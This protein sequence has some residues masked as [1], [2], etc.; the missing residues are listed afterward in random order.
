MRRIEPFRPDRPPK[1]MFSRVLSGDARG[2]AAWGAG[3]R[4][5]VLFFAAGAILTFVFG[6]GE[7]PPDLRR[8]AFERIAQRVNEPLRALQ[9]F[10][11]RIAAPGKG[12]VVYIDA[13]SAAC[14]EAAPH[15]EQLQ[16]LDLPTDDAGQPAAAAEAVRRAAGHFLEGVAPCRGPGPAGP[17]AVRGCVFQ[18]IR[19]WS[20]LAASVERL[21]KDAAWFGVEVEPL[22]PQP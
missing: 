15:V 22:A 9:P 10:R 20:S 4:L 11:A 14:V 18:C 7:R 5:I 13:Q 1:R 16:R 3:A 6:R 21:R 2:L 8:G 12:D 19:G 17:E